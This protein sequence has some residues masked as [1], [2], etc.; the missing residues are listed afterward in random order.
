MGTACAFSNQ[1]G[2][3]CQVILGAFPDVEAVSRSKAGEAFRKLRED[4]LAGRLRP[5]EKLAF[6][7]L[8]AQYSFGL[9]P[10]REALV[11]LSADGFAN[12]EEQRGF[13]VSPVSRADLLDLTR[14]SI[15][16]ESEAIS[17]AILYATP[18]SDHALLSAFHRLDVM[19]SSSASDLQTMDEAW[20]KQHTEFHNC[21]AAACDSPWL[22]R[23]RKSL[24]EQAERYR[25]I[26]FGF[27][28]NSRDLGGEHRQLMTA[29][30]ERDP[31]RARKLVAIHWQTTA[32]V[33]LRD[34]PSELWSDA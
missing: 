16:L 10:L 1:R 27:S 29:V 19:R 26:S 21:L 13:H 2:R 6:A 5:G 30:L 23:L 18:E 3:T 12:G 25:R 28:A 17:S 20:S 31:D 4:I 34:L 8:R 7:R 24:F 11:R 14:V 33:I 15:Q 32:K 9:A 22:L